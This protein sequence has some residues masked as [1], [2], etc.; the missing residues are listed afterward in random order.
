MAQLACSVINCARRAAPDV[1]GRFH[2]PKPPA[3]QRPWQSYVA[4]VR[5]RDI[6]S[7]FVHIREHV[8]LAIKAARRDGE[9]LALAELQSSIALLKHNPGQTY[10][11]A[12]QTLDIMG[13]WALWDHGTSEEV[14][15]YVTVGRQQVGVAVQQSPAPPKMPL[16]IE[17]GTKVKRTFE[18]FDEPFF[19]EVTSYA[20]P[21]FTVTYPDGDK[22][23][24][25]PSEICNIRL[26]EATVSGNRVGRVTLVLSGKAAVT[27]E[28]LPEL[29]GEEGD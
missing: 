8:K 13:A 3:P 19:G 11:T 9:E 12:L 15:Q 14:V 10:L 18:G 26:A 6:K 2:M 25:T 29:P 4:D 28:E 16:G 1:D 5:G 24:R 20:I 22:E 7:G 21:Y 27:I 23:D 17:C